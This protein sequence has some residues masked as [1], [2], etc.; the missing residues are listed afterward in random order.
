VRIPFLQRGVWREHDFS[1][2]NPIADR[3]GSIP[4][5]PHC[6]MSVFVLWVFCLIGHP[7][8]MPGSGRRRNDEPGR[9][10]FERVRKLLPAG[11]TIILNENW[12]RFA[13][14]LATG[15]S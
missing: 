7:G 12:T 1:G 3:Q 11:S 15:A 8:R 13:A 14:R 9:V 5:K 10:S 2:T 4:R 6:T